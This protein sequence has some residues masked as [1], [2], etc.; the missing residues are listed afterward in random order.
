MG[1]KQKVTKINN[2]EE[3]GPLKCDE[4]VECPKCGDIIIVS[5]NTSPIDHWCGCNFSYTSSFDED[6][7]PA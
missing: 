3:C 7:N 6:G 1:R 4:Y 5:E 2:K